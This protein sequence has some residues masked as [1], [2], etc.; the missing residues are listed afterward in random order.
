M[1]FLLL[2]FTF[3]VGVSCCGLILSTNHC[4]ACT[5]AIPS[6]EIL[7]EEPLTD[8]V[9]YDAME[10]NFLLTKS[11]LLLTQS[12][13]DGL[14]IAGSNKGSWGNQHQPTR[15]CQRLNVIVEVSQKGLVSLPLM[16]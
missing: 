8:T 16:N 5:C 10:A 7:A 12:V 6:F 1:F 2:T 9:R 4:A 15:T 14:G 13:L 3:S 11:A